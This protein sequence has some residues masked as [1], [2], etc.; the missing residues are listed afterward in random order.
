MDTQKNVFRVVAWTI[1]VL[2]MGML[3]VMLWA[4]LAGNTLLYDVLR[5]VIQLGAGII[6]VCSGLLI[7]S[8]FARAFLGNI[9][10]GNKGPYSNGKRY[11]YIICGFTLIVTDIFIAL[12]HRG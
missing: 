12:D 7:E 2:F 6:F 10:L 1:T 3:I 9:P 8:S 11:L 4:W 5:F